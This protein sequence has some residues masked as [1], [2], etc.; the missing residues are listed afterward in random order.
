MSVVL[1]ILEKILNQESFLPDAYFG[2]K[3]DIPMA[4]WIENF[5]RLRS[6]PAEEDM[7]YLTMAMKGAATLWPASLPDRSTMSL[8][9][10]LQLLGQKLTH[11]ETVAMH[12]IGRSILIPKE[13]NF[14]K[15]KLRATSWAPLARPLKRNA[16][17][18]LQKGNLLDSY[19]MAAILSDVDV[20]LVESTEKLTL[21]MAAEP[22]E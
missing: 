15:D 12:D 17:H 5:Q 2:G 9:T 3:N 22:A 11:R 1:L 21:E 16:Y 19:H 4:L 10:F 18:C 7:L 6:W 20:F 8:I 13:L 14:Q